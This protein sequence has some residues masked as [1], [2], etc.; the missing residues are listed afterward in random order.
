VWWDGA[1]E[2][3]IINPYDLQLGSE[4]ALA[5]QSV[6]YTNNTITLSFA[7][8]NADGSDGSGLLK[9]HAIGDTVGTNL[10]TEI[11]GD[12]CILEGLKGG[13]P[14][15]FVSVQ[16]EGGSIRA[17]HKSTIAMD[18]VLVY[19]RSLLPLSETI[20]KSVFWRRQQVAARTDLNYISQMLMLNR[21]LTV[22]GASYSLDLGDGTGNIS[23]MFTKEWARTVIDP[24]GTAQFICAGTIRVWDKLGA[25]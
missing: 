14:V 7:G 6:D 22:N 5:I 21:T 15:M 10:Y 11:V 18:L 3:S 4:E 2:Q 8:T 1:R 23:N 20:D 13:E 16:H 25:A 9:D 24:S 19:R 17:V 12:D